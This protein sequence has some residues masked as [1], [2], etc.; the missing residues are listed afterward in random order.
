MGAESIPA[1]LS[2]VRQLELA[3]IRGRKSEECKHYL[4]NVPLRGW[5]KEVAKP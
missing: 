1:L 5:E 2:R 3:A 4:Q